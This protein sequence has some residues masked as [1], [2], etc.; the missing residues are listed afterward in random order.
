MLTLCRSFSQDARQLTDQD[1]RELVD[2]NGDGVVTL[3]ECFEMFYEELF[4]AIRDIYKGFAGIQNVIWDVDIVLSG[5]LLLAT[6]LVYGKC[7]TALRYIPLAL[8]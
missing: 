6:A 1:F 4:P 7:R 5:I 3:E 8:G 2:I